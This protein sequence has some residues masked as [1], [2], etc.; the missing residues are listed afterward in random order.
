M[1]PTVY[2]LCRRP[3]AVGGKAGGCGFAAEEIFVGGLPPVRRRRLAVTPMLH[4]SLRLESFR[5]GLEG[6]I[7][8]LGFCNLVIQTCFGLAGIWKRNRLF[9]EEHFK[10][11]GV[12]AT[13]DSAGVIGLLQHTEGV[14]LVAGN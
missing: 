4:F 5:C 14:V 12:L 10:V 1:V 9:D 6:L 2:S 13:F 8:I 7:F 11:V 3:L